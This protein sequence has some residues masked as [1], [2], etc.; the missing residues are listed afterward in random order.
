MTTLRLKKTNGVP[1]RAARIEGTNQK[2]GLDRNWRA[3]SRTPVEDDRSDY[4]SVRGNRRV[5]LDNIVPRDIGEHIREN[6]CSRDEAWGEI[7]DALCRG[8]ADT[9][10]TNEDMKFKDGCC[11]PSPLRRH[12]LLP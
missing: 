6:R 1:P 3:V 5:K 11:C 4:Y 7:Y 12:Y 2:Y 9:A 10:P 8:H